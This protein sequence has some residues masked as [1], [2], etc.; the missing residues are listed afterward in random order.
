MNIRLIQVPYVMGIEGIYGAW[1]SPGR[2]IKAGIIEQLEQ[3]GHHVQVESIRQDQEYKNELEATVAVNQKLAP[4]VA[5][6]LHKGEFPLILGGSC[7]VS[8]G[9]FAAFEHARTGIVWFDAHGDLNTPETS[10]SGLFIGMSLGILTGLGHQTLWQEIA[11]SM[12]GTPETEKNARLDPVDIER[13][14]LVD[15][16]DLDPGEKGTVDKYAVLVEQAEKLAHNPEHSLLNTLAARA[17]DVYIH[18]DIDILDPQE[19][20]GVD[21]PVVGGSSSETVIE[22]IN[23]VSQLLPFRAAALTALNPDLDRDQLTVQAGIRI[24]IG[25]VEAANRTH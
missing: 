23:S 24:I 9:I 10:Q 22:A 2:Y 21:F 18:V 6:A 25:I 7:D 19:A 3:R 13:V 1:K 16:R 11:H 17:D 15:V 12:P 14:L 8:L 5:D 4:V 20:P